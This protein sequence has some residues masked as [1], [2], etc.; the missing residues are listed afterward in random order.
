MSLQAT[1]YF[2]DTGI[3]CSLLEIESS[4][5]LLNNPYYGNIFENSIIADLYKQYYNQGLNAPLYF[6]RDQ[7][8]ILEVDCVIESNAQLI[9]LEIKAGETY[10]PHFFDSLKK[11]V[12]LTPHPDQ[13]MYVIY[14]GTQ[15][16]THNQLHMIPWAHTGTLIQ[17][18]KR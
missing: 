16:L 17:T 1:I 6:W 10:T 11:W 2:Y 13:K 14:G 5:A 15:M 3:L 7:N 12:A 9:P 18:I 8:G 4:K